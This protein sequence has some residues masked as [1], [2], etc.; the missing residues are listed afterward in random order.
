WMITTRSFTTTQNKLNDKNADLRALTEEVPGTDFKT[1]NKKMICSFCFFQK[2]KEFLNEREYRFLSEKPGLK[3]YRIESLSKVIIG[4]R[5]DKSDKAVL[6][7]TL[8][9]LG[10][11]NKVEYAITKKNSFKIHI[12]KR[13]E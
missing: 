2:P 13:E 9:G 4:E 5:M 12:E 7:N 10:L 1:S 6:L 3:H 8:E 11:L